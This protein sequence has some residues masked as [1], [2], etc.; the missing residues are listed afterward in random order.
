MLFKD[1]LPE[2]SSIEVLFLGVGGASDGDEFRSGSLS[3]ELSISS[4]ELWFSSDENGELFL[5]P[6]AMRFS[7]RRHAE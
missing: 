1:F 6:I 5:I 4:G 3:D 7:H 2:S